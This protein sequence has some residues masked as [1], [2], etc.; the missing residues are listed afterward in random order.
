MAVSKVKPALSRRQ[1]YKSKLYKNAA[2][3][4]PDKDVCVYSTL[5]RCVKYLVVK[6]LWSRSGVF[7]R[8]LHRLHDVPLPLLHGR[9]QTGGQEGVG[10]FIVL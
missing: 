10:G 9:H 7:F 5:K 3:L 4:I 8:S 2:W 1:P 6:I